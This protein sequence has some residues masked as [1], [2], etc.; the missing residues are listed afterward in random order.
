MRE[1]DALTDPFMPVQRAHRLRSV[2]VGR[3]RVPARRDAGVREDHRLCAA[4]GASQRIRRRQ[5]SRKSI[6]SNGSSCRILSR[7]TRAAAA[8]RWI[9]STRRRSICCRRSRND[10]NIVIGEVWPIETYAVLRF[11][12]IRPPF[13]NLK[14][15]QAVAHAF[16]QRDYMSAAY[17]D[18]KYWRECYAYLDMRQPERHRGRIRGIS[19]AGPGNGAALVRESGYDGAPVVLIGGSDIPPISG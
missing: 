5:G 18:P 14:A 7:L 6:A 3:R 10:P 16:S 17:G 8:A 11:N 1:K 2:P 19:Q 13:N 12:S 4:P 15:R 9:S